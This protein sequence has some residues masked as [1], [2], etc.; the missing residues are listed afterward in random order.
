M[1][2]AVMLYDLLGWMILESK[3][4][5][6][7]YCSYLYQSP[8]VMHHLDVLSFDSKASNTA[9]M[10]EVRSTLFAHIGS[11]FESTKTDTAEM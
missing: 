5:A 6:S 8:P 7:L 2:Y 3:Y 1:V 11:R 10:V 4:R 9:T